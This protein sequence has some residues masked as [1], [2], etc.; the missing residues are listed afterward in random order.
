LPYLVVGRWRLTPFPSRMPL[1]FVVGAPIAAPDLPLGEEVKHAG[2]AQCSPM[3]NG[4][5]WQ[6]ES[7]L[8]LCNLLT[9]GDICQ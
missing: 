4:V 2:S 9:A 1:K 3:H 7:N 6:L 5:S 8:V